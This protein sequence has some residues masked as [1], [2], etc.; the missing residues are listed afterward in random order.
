MAKRR[1]DPETRWNVRQIP[2]MAARRAWV[3]QQFALVQ[4]ARRRPVWCQINT[5]PRQGRKIAYPSEEAAVAAAEHLVDMRS[6]PVKAYRCH[7][8]HTHWHLCT[9]LSKLPTPKEPTP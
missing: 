9:D 3:L 4:D 6:R 1:R 8:D 5:D 2:K 7:R